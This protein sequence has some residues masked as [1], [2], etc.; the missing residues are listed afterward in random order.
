MKIFNIGLVGYGKMGKIYAR[1]IKLNNKFNLKQILTKKKINKNSKCVKEFFKRKDLDIFI[2][3]SPI[4]THFKYL[5][6][7]YAANKDIIIEKPLV[8]NQNQLKKLVLLN[9]NFKKKVLIHHNDVLNFEKSKIIQKFVKF[10]K[11]KKVEMIYGK[12]EYRNSFIKPHFDW[13]PHPIAVMFNLFGEPKKFQI[14][15]YVKVNKKNIILE[16]LDLFF[17]FKNFKVFVKFS[18]N[19][20]NPCKKITIY[21]DNKKLIYDGYIPKN[22]RTIKILLEKYYFSNTINDINS[23][24]NAYKLLFKIDKKLIN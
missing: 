23:Y 5:K 13:L 12:K 9:K 11:I 3:A 15:D 16:N 10:K 6:Y 21:Q 18:N 1:E 24:I 22:Q 7:A 14:L 4:T 2:I 19:L 8:E 20:K 17:T